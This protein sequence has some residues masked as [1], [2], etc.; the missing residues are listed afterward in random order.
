MNI[1]LGVIELGFEKIKQLAVYMCMCVCL[2][3]IAIK[4]VFNNCN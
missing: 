2:E 4:G 3:T 1:T